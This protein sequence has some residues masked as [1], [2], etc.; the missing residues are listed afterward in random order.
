MKTINPEVEN[1][2]GGVCVVC[3]CVNIHV[4]DVSIFLMTDILHLMKLILCQNKI[5]TQSAFICAILCKCP[6]T[7]FF[8]Y[9]LIFIHVI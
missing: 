7:H 8:S 6:V 4:C 5:I 1:V 2:R 9:D 3:V